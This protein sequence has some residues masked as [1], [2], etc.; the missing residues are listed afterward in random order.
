MEKVL[1]QAK[2]GMKIYSKDHRVVQAV[3]MWGKINNKKINFAYPE[4]VN[5]TWP[6]FWEFIKNFQQ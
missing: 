1:E 5:K 3:A 6:Q 4:V 2:N